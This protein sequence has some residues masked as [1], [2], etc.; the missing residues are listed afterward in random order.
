MKRQLSAII[1]SSAIALTL[2]GCGGSVS[3][4]SVEEACKVAEDGVKAIGEKHGSD[5]DNL[6]SAFDASSS[7]IGEVADG[8]GSMTNMLGELANDMRQIRGINNREVAGAWNSVMSEFNNLLVVLD[9]MD[10]RK[11][12]EVETRMTKSLTDFGNICPNL[13]SF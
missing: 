6:G 10:F 12:A 9:N 13:S 3:N 2:S 7:S 4:Q 1:A 8:I 11:M 5:W